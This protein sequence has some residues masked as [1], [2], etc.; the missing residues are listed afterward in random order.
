MKKLF[1]IF[2][3]YIFISQSAS[4]QMDSIV[5]YCK[6]YLKFPYL[7]DGQQYRALVSEG[8]IAEFR[9]TFYGGAV[10]RIVT[11]SEPKD[12]SVIFRLYDKNKTELFSNSK[13]NNSSY[14]DFSFGSTVDCYIEAELPPNKKSGFILMFLGFKQ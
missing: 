9:I 12:G 14:W 1:S 11:A 10:Y 3:L 8:E 2:I 5:N 7:S 4:A 13:Y 6:G